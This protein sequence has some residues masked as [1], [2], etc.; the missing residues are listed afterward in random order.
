MYPGVGVK[1]FVGCRPGFNVTRTHHS[2]YTEAKSFAADNHPAA[3]LRSWDLRFEKR[4][5]LPY[6]SPPAPRPLSLTFR[7]AQEISNEY[8][9]FPGLNPE[10]SDEMAK[11]SYLKLNRKLHLALVC[12]LFPAAALRAVVVMTVELPLSFSLLCSIDD[13][14][15]LSCSNGGDHGYHRV[16]CGPLLYCMSSSER[17]LLPFGRILGRRLLGYKR[18]LTRDISFWLVYFPRVILIN[19]PL[20]TE[21]ALFELDPTLQCRLARL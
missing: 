18:N 11:E 7:C 20:A 21:D 8:W 2:S 3:F 6:L 16:V 13:S 9:C 1:I 12:H 19:E 15:I 17:R 5:R 4:C 14:V 10:G